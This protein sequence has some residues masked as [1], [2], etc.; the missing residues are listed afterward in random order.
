MHV[1]ITNPDSHTNMTLY[2]N[3]THWRRR[4]VDRLSSSP[5]RRYRRPMIGAFATIS[6]PTVIGFELQVGIV[7]IRTIGLRVIVTSIRSRAQ[8]NAEQNGCNHLIVLQ[9]TCRDVYRNFATIRQICQV[10][11]QHSKIRSNLEIRS[12]LEQIANSVQNSHSLGSH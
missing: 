4:P 7:R 8:Q 12:D 1:Y 11:F 2:E 3:S 9:K 5:V 10:S 6:R